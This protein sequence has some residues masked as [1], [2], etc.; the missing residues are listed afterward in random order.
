MSVWNM[1]YKNTPVDEKERKD[2]NESKV[3]EQ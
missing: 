2:S 1:T 3:I